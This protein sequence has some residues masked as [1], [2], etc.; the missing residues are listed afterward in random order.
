MGGRARGKRTDGTRVQFG[1]ERERERGREGREDERSSWCEGRKVMHSLTPLSVG[2][3]QR[4][5]CNCKRER[6]RR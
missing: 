4:A 1:T 5:N 2:G 3:H 6:G